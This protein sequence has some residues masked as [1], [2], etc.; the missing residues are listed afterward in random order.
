LK[1]LTPD[2]AVREPRPARRI[3]IGRGHEVEDAASQVASSAVASL[4]MP[5]YNLVRSDGQGV[6]LI[7]IG[8]GLPTPRTSP[9]TWRCCGRIAG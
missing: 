3:A 8:V 6:T 1:Q 7:N 2:G 9:T 4:Q 5:A